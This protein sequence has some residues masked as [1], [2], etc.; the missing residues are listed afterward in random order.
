METRG[1]TGTRMT[2]MSKIGKHAGLAT[3][4][5]G[6]SNVRTPCG[7]RH[8]ANL[9][10]GDLVV[11]RDHALQPVRMIWKRVVTLSEMAADP[12]L[13]PI[14]LKPRCIGPMMPQRDLLVAGDHR[15]LIPGYRLIDQP[16]TPAA[17]LPARDIAGTSDGAFVDRSR[18]EVTYYNL[19]FDAHEV[20]S[21]NGLPVESFLP[22]EDN[23]AK[24]ET[25]VRQTIEQTLPD[26]TAADRVYQVLRY[27]TTSADHYLPEFA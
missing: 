9:R 24:V 6:N 21:A 4:L 15:I 5:C 2:V 22:S 20:F 7:A 14:C 11:T 12:S 19:I 10:P 25:P 13:A 23:L 27:P 8:V 26:L 17:L 3:G 16:G 18:D 1:N